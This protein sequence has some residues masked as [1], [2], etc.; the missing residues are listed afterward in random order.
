MAN[1]VSVVDWAFAA[2]LFEGEGCIRIHLGRRGGVIKS[3]SL[4]CQIT[5]VHRDLL[6]WLQ[7]RFN[8]SVLREQLNIRGNRRATWQWKLSTRDAGDF[9]SG[10]NP[11]L[12]RA[13]S[14]RKV[15]MA[16]AFLALSPS[17]PG[18]LQQAIRL[19]EMLSK[20][21]K[22]GAS[23]VVESGLAEEAVWAFT[24]IRPYR[25]GC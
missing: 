18:Y 23:G 24:D 6:E 4:N 19:H 16:R 3:V 22:V 13:I 7:A 20:L 2:G 9:V 1:C 8:G 25:R 10:I 12:V 14:K 11:Y 15:C 17:A 21:N 5:Q